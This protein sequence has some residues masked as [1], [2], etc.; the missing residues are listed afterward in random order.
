[1]MF[2]ALTLEAQVV[3]KVGIHTY[4]PTEILHVNGTMRVENLPI[5]GATNSIYTM[6]DG[7]ASSTKNQTF[8]ARASVV[9]DGNGVLGKSTHMLPVFFYMPSVVLPIQA[10]ALTGT[11]VTFDNGTNKFQI[12]LYKVYKEQFSM[13]VSNTVKNP[14]ATENIQVI[15]NNTQLDYFVTYFDNQVYDK[16]GITNAGILTYKVKSSAVKTP[17]TYMNIVLKIRYL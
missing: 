4:N 3:N 8:N 12:D 15:P 17:K 5:H 2:S 1:M 16:V 6:P 10:D 7:T 9:V 13:S 11:N 14:G